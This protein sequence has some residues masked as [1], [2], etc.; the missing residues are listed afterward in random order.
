MVSLLLASL[1][2]VWGIF[3][4]VG[5][6]NFKCA[7]LT[8]VVELLYYCTRYQYFIALYPYSLALPLFYYVSSMLCNF[9]KKPCHYLLIICSYNYILRTFDVC[10]W[11]VYCEH[12]RCSNSQLKVLMQHFSYDAKITTSFSTCLP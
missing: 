9:A 5:V 7:D 6:C 11:S 3:L 4:A 8:H 12:L 10:K 1:L 2:F